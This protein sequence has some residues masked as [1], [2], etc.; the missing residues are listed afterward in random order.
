MYQPHAYIAC[1]DQNNPSRV[2]NQF[3][4][5]SVDYT[6]P[7]PQ[8]WTLV[9]NWQANVDPLHI[10]WNNGLFDDEGLFEVTTF[11][12]GRT[13]ALVDNHAYPYILKELCELGTN[14]LRF[15]GLFPM[16]GSGGRWISLGPDGSARATTIGA[17]QWYESTL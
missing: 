11:T 13:Y 12:N 14:Q 7:L 17:A 4:E 2:F 1:V 6:K 8:A 10:S 9:N 3:L 15:T 16:L 5:F